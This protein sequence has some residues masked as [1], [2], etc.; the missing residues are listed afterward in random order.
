MLLYR[1]VAD[2]DG[3]HIHARPH[4]YVIANGVDQLGTGKTMRRWVAAMCVGAVCVVG[5]PLASAQPAEDSFYT[6]SGTTPLSEYE[7]GAVLATRTV[8]YHLVNVPTPIQAVQILYRSTDA[9]DR[10]TEN[11]TSILRTPNAQ[12]GKVVAYQSAYDSL[13]PADGPSRAVAGDSPLLTLTPSG[14][15]VTVGGLLPSGEGGVVAPLLLLGYTVVLTDTQGPKADFGA[16]PE[17]GKLTLDSLR[18]AQRVPETGITDSAKIGLLGYS[19]GAIATNWAAILAPDYAPDLSDNLI[20]AAQGGV[21]ANPANNLRYASGSL[22]WAGVVG[23]ALVGISRA[24]DISFEKYLSDRGRDVMHHLSDASIINVLYQYPG[25]KWSDLVKP[26][27][28]DP[29]SV[30][31]FV[32]TANKLNMGHAPIPEMPMFIAQA[33]NGILEGTPPGPAGIGPGDGIMIAGDVRSLVNRY[34]DAG[35]VIQYD[36]YDTISHIPGAA[37][38]FP[39]AL[40][41]LTE[42]FA[43]K[44]APSNCGRIAPG[45]SLALEEHRPI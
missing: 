4:G 30:P 29:N 16:G 2:G 23:M 42:R 11:V 3:A 38:W 18:A 26:E 36:E 43:D 27:Y 34:C 39:G 1:S 13:N 35:N 28:A 10:P 45:N 7:P 21:L 24:Y 41:W 22:G 31:E 17:Y 9:L 5:A 20:G 25:L 44:P 12:P 6:Y 19:G 15:N 8:Q 14:R 32:D 33:S 40:Q 37:L